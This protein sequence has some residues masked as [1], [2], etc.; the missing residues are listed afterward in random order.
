MAMTYSENGLHLTEQFE[1]LRLA[2]YKDSV[3]VPT[4][5]YGHTRNVTMDMSCTQEQAEQWLQ[6]D[7]QIAVNGVNQLVTVALTQNQFDALVDFAF[8]LG[9]GSLQHST[10][11]RLLNGGDYA[12]AAGEFE[13][14]NKAGGNVLPGLVKRRQ[15]ERDL[16]NS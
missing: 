10:L 3:G 16:F 2:A 5:G 9:V 13:K 11:L 7:V 14:W 15:A 6:D 12:G 8:N 4:I 1:G